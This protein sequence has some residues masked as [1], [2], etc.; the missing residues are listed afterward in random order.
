M[1][2]QRSGAIVNC[3]SLGGL[4]GNPGRRTYHATKHG[5]I[6]LTQSIA[7]QYAPPG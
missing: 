4:A 6:G 1:R 5:V 7:I 3:S 2:A